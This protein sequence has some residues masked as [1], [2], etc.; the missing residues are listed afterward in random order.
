MLSPLETALIALLLVVLMFGMGATLTWERFQ[1]VAR[2]PK[3]F[4]I[5]TASQFG[6]MPLLAYGL[7]KGLELPPLAALGLVVMGTCPGGTTSNL[8]AH[9]AK[10]DVALSIAMTA[11]SKV[12]GI[13]M[14]PLC[15]YLYARPFTETNMPIPYGDVIKTLIVLLVPVAIAMLLRRRYGER[16]AHV[17]ERVGSTSGM[18][19][20]LALVGISVVRN[21]ALFATLTLPMCIAAIALGLFGMLAGALIARA[22]GLN[23]AQRR[24]VSFETGVQN[25]PLCF[26]I[27]VSAFPGEGQLELLKLPLLYALFVLIEAALATVIYRWLDKREGALADVQ[28]AASAPLSLCLALA[29]GVALSACS[30]DGT[31]NPV[32]PSTSEQNNQSNASTDAGSAQTGA[33]SNTPT[34]TATDAGASSAMTPVKSDAG[35]STTAAVDAALPPV[36]GAVTYYQDVKPFMDAKCVR[37]HV[38][39]TVAPFALD[40]YDLAKEHGTIA[41][42]AVM[43]GSM[44]PWMFKDGCNDYK[45]NFSLTPQE[46]ATLYAWVDQGMP[47][48]DASK[49][50]A[51]IDIGE[52]GLSR[53][54]V[55]LQIPE[56]YTSTMEQPDEYRCFPVLWPSK[57]TK[58]TFMTG[59]RAVPGNP[60][61]VHHVEVY[62]IPKAQV[63]TVMQKDAA[64]P[65]PGY[66]CFGGPGAGNGTVG[67]WAPGSP[68]YDYPPNVGIKIE[69]GSAMVIQVHYNT[70][71]VG[72]SEPDQSKVEFKVDDNVVEG[73]YDFWMNLVWSSG[74]MNIPAGKSDVAFDWTADPTSLNTPAVMAGGFGGMGS[75]KPIMV[76]T[77]GIHMHN[78]GT[79]GYMHLKRKDG[80]RECI[81]ELRDWDFHWQGGVRLQKPILINPGDVIEMECRFDN[82]QQNQP[83][84]QGRQQTPRNV[85]WGENTTDEMCLGI[86]LWGQQ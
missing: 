17:A 77:A 7:A 51:K 27:L 62:Y 20:L 16:F 54:D 80:T 34:T 84:Y 49:P 78:L 1:A 48:G 86:L 59:Y 58:D 46:K 12:L 39:G 11:A 33:P 57:Y 68:G 8:F 50:G 22:A 82:S 6:W 85:N 29:C 38:V 19:L 67:G 4:L 79:T 61:V 3:A 10:A 75:G 18:V 66:T 44:P 55:S 83:V 25:S 31:P 26:A 36:T 9:L 14:M 35:M 63:Q 81:V 42:A 60:R 53:V 41:K 72:H 15:L 30:D 32:A 73:G 64:D 40:S 24:T 5:G 37:C 13:V 65:G 45:G 43:S 23:T 71:T 52:V 70:Q 74:G 21:H 2:E 28:S 56:P 69:A 76:Y 47:A